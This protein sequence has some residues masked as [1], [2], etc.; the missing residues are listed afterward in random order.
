MPPENLRS[1]GHD[2]I[3][4]HRA[5]AEDAQAL[6]ALV[7]SA[8]RGESSR[9]GWT[10][11]ADLLGGQRV[12]IEGLTATISTP[13]NVILV[14]EQDNEPIACVH[15]ARTGEDCYLGMLTVRPTAQGTGL[16]RKL[17]EA[18]ERWAIDHW[19]SR[20]VHMAVI[21]QRVELIA[22]YE[23]HG[24]SRTGERKPFPYGDERFG[25]PK[26]DDLAFEIL[27]KAL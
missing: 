23:R 7:N 8:Y 2:R 15:L 27:S 3:G 13:G 14:H 12:D 1:P 10:T 18:A 20:S 16:G 19:A 25:Q 4:M 26:R 21:K 22:W 9:A 6:V 11:E 17:L 24:Y 5:T